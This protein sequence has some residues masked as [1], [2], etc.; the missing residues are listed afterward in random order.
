VQPDIH[1][2][3]DGVARHEPFKVKFPTLC[4]TY[5][6]LDCMTY[7]DWSILKPPTCMG[8]IL[9]C[10]QEEAEKAA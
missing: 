7:E 2:R 5:V 6:N 1:I 10:F 8:C 9:V 3:K 4:G